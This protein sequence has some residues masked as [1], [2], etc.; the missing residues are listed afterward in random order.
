MNLTAEMQLYPLVKVVAVLIPGMIVARNFIG[1]ISCLAWLICFIA[2]LL[3][4]YLFRRL[5][6]AQSG[7][8]YFSI[9]FLGGFL[10]ANENEFANVSLPSHPIFYDAVVLSEPERHGKV[11][12]ADLGVLNNDKLIKV[13]ASILRDTVSNR[14]QHLHVG[15]GIKAYSRM[16]E[17]VNFPGSD[18]DYATWMKTQGYVFTTFIYFNNWEK[19][20][21]DL[22]SLN[23]WERATLLVKRF[24]HQLLRQYE[25]AC[26]KNDDLAVVSAMTLGYKSLLSKNVKDDY[27]VAGA[28]HL[29][30]L[31]GLHLSIIY[32]ALLFLLSLFRGI[33][34]MNFLR[35]L[36]VKELIALMAVWAY[37]AIVDFSPSVVRSALML[38]IFAAISLL[39]RD[40]LSVNTLAL[41]AIIMLVVHP[42][43]LYDIGF[44]MSFMAVL[45]ISLFFPILYHLIPT[46]ILQKVWVLRWLWSIMVVS[47]AAQLGTAP[48]V[49]H[50]FQRISCYFFLTNLFAIPC[51]LIILYLA[52]AMF[53]TY[54]F[55]D[56]YFFILRLMTGISGFLNSTLHHIASLP[57][58]SI[59]NIN[60]SAFQV[61]LIYVFLLICWLL[62][63][64][65]SDR[66]EFR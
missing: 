34:G 33:P 58:A 29:L 50:Y 42:M 55:P 63:S 10:M 46:A 56:I 3:F 36:A 65:F 52:V 41:A 39:K 48:L 8:L 43:N 5:K 23:H 6:F 18:F 51:A 62:S 35:N 45:S 38:T 7:L 40:K 9:F 37:V 4:S 49:A 53:A 32:G 13:K 27:S 60:P 24:R 16:E 66:L 17:P 20:S 31:S 44:E 1:E 47:I 11:V 28:S 15:D 26:G 25:S 54:A 19:V 21:L 14:Y 64:F 59:E 61:F 22:R 2:F 30:A 57:G 12:Q